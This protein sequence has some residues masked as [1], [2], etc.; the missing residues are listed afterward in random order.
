M[1]QLTV[2][3]DDIWAGT[4]F[5]GIVGYNV[6]TGLFTQHTRVNNCVSDIVFNAVAADKS[7]V[8][9]NTIS[10]PSGPGSIEGL[11]EAFQPTLNTGTGK[12]GIQLAVPPGT[13]GHAPALSLSYEGGSGNGPLI[14]LHP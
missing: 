13:A 7:G 5:G 11:G 3:G 4:G 10:L 12:Y 6:T 2:T 9:P 14:Q 1:L 8:T